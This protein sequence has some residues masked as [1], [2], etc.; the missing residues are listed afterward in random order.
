MKDDKET[1]ILQQTLED[2]AQVVFCYIDKHNQNRKIKKSNFHQRLDSSLKPPGC[3]HT[4]VESRCYNHLLLIMRVCVPQCKLSILFSKQ[5]M[6]LLLFLL[7]WSLFHLSE[8]KGMMT[9]W[10]SCRVNCQTNL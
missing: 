2:A 5:T 10:T 1:N 7:L 9:P 6:K 3:D 8:S 4:I